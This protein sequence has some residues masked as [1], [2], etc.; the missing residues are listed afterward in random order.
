MTRDYDVIVVGGA[1]PDVSRAV[2]SARLEPALSL[3]P[4]I[5]T[6]WPR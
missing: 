6:V 4:T 3:Y 5:S 1:M 2:S